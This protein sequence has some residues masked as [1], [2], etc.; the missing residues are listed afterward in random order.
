MFALD[1]PM[2]DWAMVS[3]ER[4]RPNTR[5]T[6]PR[7]R[8]LSQGLASWL[9]WNK[10]SLECRSARIAHLERYEIVTGTLAQDS[11]AAIEIFGTA[12]RPI[13]GFSFSQVRKGDPGCS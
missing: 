6:N 7:R 12:Y 3:E 13:S 4:M 2:L 8:M 5:T 11:R 9:I 1:V 10:N